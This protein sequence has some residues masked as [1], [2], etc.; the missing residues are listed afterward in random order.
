MAPAAVLTE[1]PLPDE[2][3]EDIFLR[4]DDAADL[5]RAFATC[6]SF[7]RV[8]RGRRFLHRFRSLHPPPVLCLG[9]LNQPAAHGCFRPVESP[10]RSTSAARALVQ[11]ADFTFSFLPDPKSWF[12]RDARDGRV[13]LS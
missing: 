2:V 12:I 6:T 4:L 7:R 8:V 5:A 13:L 3:M 1:P 9:G 10:H 11:A